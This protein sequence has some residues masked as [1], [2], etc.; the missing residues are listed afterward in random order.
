MP[1]VLCFSQVLCIFDYYSIGKIVNTV[2]KHSPDHGHTAMANWK[3]LFLKGDLWVLFTPPI[4]TC[5]VTEGTRRSGNTLAAQLMILRYPV[6][7]ISY[8]LSTSGQLWILVLQRARTCLTLSRLS[9]SA[10]I[11]LKP[12][13]Q[14]ARNLCWGI[15]FQH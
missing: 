6:L 1:E 15:D 8:S 2:Y 9:G 4:I 5:F 7:F 12:W 10:P 3:L 13:Q 11:N 14:L